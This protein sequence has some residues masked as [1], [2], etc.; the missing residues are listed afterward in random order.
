MPNDNLCANAV[1]V[2]IF[3][4]HSCGIPPGLSCL[5]L[6]YPRAREV[7]EWKVDISDYPPKALKFWGVEGRWVFGSDAMLS[8]GTAKLSQFR[9]ERQTTR[10]TA[11]VGQ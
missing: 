7:P 4:T 10:E 11:S 8:S 1:K 3:R 9:G 2:R 5:P 6:D